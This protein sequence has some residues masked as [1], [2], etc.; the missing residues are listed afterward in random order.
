M[1]ACWSLKARSARTFLTQAAALGRVAAE[2]AN[3][4]L[5]HRSEKAEVDQ[6]SAAWRHTR[7]VADVD[8]AAV[9]ATSQPVSRTRRH[10]SAG[11][12]A[13]ISAAVKR[14]T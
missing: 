6:G 3:A 14:D 13:P 4:A 11:S 1:E 7:G 8:A 2:E 5:D 9:A 10:S 12:S